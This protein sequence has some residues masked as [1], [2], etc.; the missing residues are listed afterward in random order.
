MSTVVLA[1]T[2]T[3]SF[4]EGGGHWWV[5]LQYVLALRD[6][7]FRVIWLERVVGQAGIAQALD[8]L[9]DF[10][11][12]R[13]DILLYAD[14]VS[15]PD[16]L[17]QLE[18]LV[19]S[20]AR[21]EHALQAEVLLNFDYASPAAIVESAYRSALIDI[22]PGLLQYWWSRGHI[23][24]AGHHHWVSTGETVGTAAALTDCAVDWHRIRVPI[25]LPSWPMC[26][27]PPT[28]P[29]TTVTSWWGDEWLTDDQGTAIENNKRVGFVPYFDLP[30]RTGLDLELAA[31]FGETVPH[32][33][34][35]DDVTPDYVGG[36]GD[37][38]AALLA[39]GW[40]L[41]RSRSVSSDPFAY[42]RYIQHSK[43]EFSCVKPSCLLFQNAWISDRSL[44]YLA[45]G[46]PV[47]VEN[48]GPSPLLDGGRGLLR[49]SSP[50]EAAEALADVEANYPDHQR[51]ARELIEA[52]FSAHDIVGGLLDHVTSP[53]GRLLNSTPLA[54]G[55]T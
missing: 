43:G 53:A 1:P 23:S 15:E 2:G 22:D 39:G 37:D 50:D 48:T 40:R 44:C 24:P 27:E 25:H 31:Y 51:A 11:F 14:P 41:R 36:D 17:D 10:G 16:A 28:G 9:E 5:Y 12:D 19:G 6:L 32:G 3:C 38:V 29:Y 47:V 4:P 46:R 49:F 42:R 26:D 30:V 45:S 21:A 35:R 33:G 8:L 20:A 7:G 34:H 52:H 18:W 55:R 54:T 13:D